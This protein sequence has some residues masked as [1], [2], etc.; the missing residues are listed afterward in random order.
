MLNS[1]PIKYHL[2]VHMPSSK[3]SSMF[4]QRTMLS[5][6]SQARQERPSRRSCMWKAT[7]LKSLHYH[8]WELTED[9]C[10]LSYQ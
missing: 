9:S 1:L 6:F 2:E 7:H 10:F 8:H 5:P 4:F 3:T